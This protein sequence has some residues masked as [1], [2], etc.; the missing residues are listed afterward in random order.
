[1][2]NI[3]YFLLLLLLSNNVI[4]QIND[5]TKRMVHLSSNV[6]FRD[7]GGYKTKDGK[8]V[9]WGMIYRSA[10]INKLNETDL[11]ELEKRKITVDFDFRG[12]EES[13]K[14]PDVLWKNLQYIR[15]GAGSETTTNWIQSLRGVKNGDSLMISFYTKIDSFGIKYK[16]LFNH[17]LNQNKNEATLYHC[18]AGKDR[19]G[20]ATALILYALD[21]PEETIIED[22]K[23][24]NYYREN[25]N[26]KMTQMISSIGVDKNVAASMMLVKESYLKATAQEIIKHYGSIDN[27]LEKELGI[28]EKEK[29]ILRSKFLE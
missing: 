27:F 2:K 15:C 25:E 7:I 10:E 6:N 3:Y 16:P 8:Q 19:T 17:L 18:S 28:G 21:V 12:F 5:S 20:I 23:A 29:Q 14:A 13:K 24:S 4:A 11:N 26:K 1:M 9:K 22:Y